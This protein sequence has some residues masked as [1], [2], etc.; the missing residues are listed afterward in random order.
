MD[1]HTYSL[2]TY[3]LQPNHL[4]PISYSLITN[5]LTTNCVNC[6]A[7]YGDMV[8]YLRYASLILLV[9]LMVTVG[10]FIVT[11]YS[12]LPKEVVQ[13]N[14]LPDTLRIDT[15]S[16]LTWNIG[17]AGLGKEMDFF[18]D[19]GLMVRGTR[20]DAD[21]N[22]KAIEAF[23]QSFE[24]DF[25]I[26][27]EVDKPSKRSHHIDQYASIMS[28]LPKYKASFALNYK[29]LYVPTPI[30]GPYGKVVSGLMTLSGLTP[31]KVMRISLG[32]K[33]PWPRRLFMP[34]RAVLETRLLLPTGKEL[35]LLN[36]HCE[37]FDS[38]N[39]RRVE[40]ETIRALIQTEYAKG[41]SVIVGGDWN[42]N[43]PGIAT[44]TT[45]HFNPIQ[46]SQSYAP[47]GWRWSVPSQPTNRYLNEPYLAGKTLTTTLDFFL[48]SPNL[49][50]LSINRIDLG[51]ENSDH[52][53]V[54]MK[55]MLYNK[56]D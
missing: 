14:S 13:S 50:P 51:F 35:V 38:G 1:K 30:A 48:L 46:I 37:A 31:E 9:A 56:T 42:Q 19:G 29:S 21:L 36:I 40:M 8:R 47:K 49:K 17:Y 55:F 52:N 25:I 6:P 44:P 43:P 4:Q 15:I 20:K 34:K 26:L 10:I 33:Y 5:S 41:N 27:Q 24:A 18:F 28:A 12:P 2:T 3:S 22:L 54:V 39:L 45:K 16:V 53:P 11:E 32:S 23:L 7:N